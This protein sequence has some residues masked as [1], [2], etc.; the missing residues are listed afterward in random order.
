MRNACWVAAA[1]LAFLAAVWWR[2]GGGPPPW[3]P[4]P[5]LPAEPGDLVARHAA[6][7]AQER[8]TL[9][10]AARAALDAL[11]AALGGF[12]AEGADALAQAEARVA[13]LAGATGG[14]A[15]VV[16]D[17][18][19]P[20]LRRI[21][22][23]RLLGVRRDRR[24]VPLLGGLLSAGDDRP[25]AALQTA[26]AE[27]LGLIGDRAALPELLAP[28]F[29]NRPR[30]WRLTTAVGVAALHLGAP[31]GGDACLE[32][33]D[34]WSPDLAARPRVFDREL[35][36]RA[37]LAC[38]ARLGDPPPAAEPSPYRLPVEFRAEVERFRVW[39]RGARARVRP[40]DGVTTDAVLLRAL[41]APRLASFSGERLFLRKLAQDVLVALGADGLPYALHAL[42]DPREP[43]RQYGAES[44]GAMASAGAV[45]HLAAAYAREPS[46]TVRVEVVRALGRLRAEATADADARARADATLAAAAGDPDPAVRAAAR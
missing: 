4:L 20:L 1:L 29:D 26:A 31:A 32:V 36:G 3:P 30:D 40:A 8:E 15:A 24:A 14:L 13:T 19:A 7:L 23:C 37:L 39:W 28:L 16:A 38:A 9:D 5:P 25:P 33:L 12:G 43:W 41:L 44:L 2:F 22:A 45:G 42:R 10:P 11:V 34:D 6:A 46:A 21:D 27:A 18:E 17:A 35:A